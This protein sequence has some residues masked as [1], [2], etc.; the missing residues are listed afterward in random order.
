[1]ELHLQKCSQK[2]YRREGNGFFKGMVQ[3]TCLV[4]FWLI[5]QPMKLL[6]IRFED[7]EAQGGYRASEQ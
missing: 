5:L 3:G 4:G 1:M 7:T 2:S 6:L